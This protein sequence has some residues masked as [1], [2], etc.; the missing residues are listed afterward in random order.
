MSALAGSLQ[1]LSI[2]TAK[3]EPIPLNPSV[4]PCTPL[5]VF[6]LFNVGDTWLPVKMTLPNFKDKIFV[7]GKDCSK[8][9]KG[10]NTWLTA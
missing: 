10:I 4:E 7:N 3:S 1:N 9:G 6:P 8:L 2:E 5:L